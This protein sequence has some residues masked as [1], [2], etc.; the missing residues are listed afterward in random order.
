MRFSCEA[1]CSPWQPYPDRRRTQGPV[2]GAQLAKV[3]TTPAVQGTIW[4]EAAGGVP[5]GA[6]GRKA[7]VTGDCNWDILGGAGRPSAEL[8]HGVDSE[9][10]SLASGGQD[11]AMLPA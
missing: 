10:V 6:E 9:T 3:V 7:E 1:F 4:G 11:A 5:A 2:P 8:T